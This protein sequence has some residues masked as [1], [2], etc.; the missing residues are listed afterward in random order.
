MQAYAAMSE[1]HG[2]TATSAPERQLHFHFLQSPCA[3]EQDSS[4]AVAG[5]QL[6]ATRL[7]TDA[8]GAQSVERTGEV[9]TLPVD[10]LL[11]SVGYRAVPVEGVPF[12]QQ[13]AVIPN[14]LGRVATSAAPDATLEPGLYTC[15]WVKRGPSGIIGT[16]VVDAEQTAG[17]VAEDV[18]AGVVPRGGGGGDALQALLKVSATKLKQLSPTWRAAAYISQLCTRQC[19][20]D[21]AIRCASVST[22]KYA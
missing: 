13:H 17:C 11:K 9:S 20:V 7:C 18:V 3:V 15:G 12:D 8:V 14:A 22:A 5:V 4:G 16:N 1:A 2:R 19:R 6:H 21:L 10:L